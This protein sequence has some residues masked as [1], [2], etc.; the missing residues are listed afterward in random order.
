[1]GSIK[2]SRA[3]AYLF[4]VACSK[5]RAFEPLEPL[6]LILLAHCVYMEDLGR[7]GEEGIGELLDILVEM[8]NLSLRVRTRKLDFLGLCLC[9]GRHKFVHCGGDDEQICV[10]VSG[11]CR[12]DTN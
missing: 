10:F 1:M 5:T 3:D 6:Q 11:L 8:R 9:A 7:P 12:F 4:Y 2:L